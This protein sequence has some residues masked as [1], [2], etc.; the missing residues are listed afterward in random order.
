M[1]GLVDSMPDRLIQV[2]AS[3]GAKIQRPSNS[4]NDDSKSAFSG[5]TET[6]NLIFVN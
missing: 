6:I 4:G 1:N 2:I 3:N 5:P